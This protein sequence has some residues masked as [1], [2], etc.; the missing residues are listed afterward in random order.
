MSKYFNFGEKVIDISNIEE[1][2]E[3]YDEGYVFTRKSIGNVV[4]I[5]GL[6]IALANFKLSSENR[7]ILKKFEINLNLEKIPYKKYNYQIQKLGKDFYE[8]KSGKNTFSAYKIKQLFLNGINFNSIVEF[9]NKLKDNEMLH[10]STISNEVLDGYVIILN[11]KGKKS[12][13]HYA[14]PFYKA[15]LIGKNFGM[16]MMTKFIL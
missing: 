8:M 13:A 7:R 14:Y 4:R 12:I 6:R 10:G 16:F 1:V 2:I 3:A 9:S 11:L 5:R 15:E